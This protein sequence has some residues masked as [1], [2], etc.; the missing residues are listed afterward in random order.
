MATD[1]FHWLYEEGPCFAVAK[2]GGLL[3]QAPPHIDSLE[4]RLRRF[5]QQRDGRPG[6]VYL[7]VPHR[8]D[9]PVSGVLVFA[10]HV[11][12]AR[13]ISRQFEQRTV[14]KKYWALLEGCLSEEEGEWVDYL[15]KVPDQPRGE[16]VDTRR[17]DAR[18]AVLR[19]RRL[20]QADDCA[21]VEI[22]LQTGR[23]HQIRVQAAS[24]GHPVVGDVEY[25]STRPFGPEVLDHRQRW[26]ALHA[27]SLRFD[28]PMHHESRMITAPIPP[29]WP[30]FVLELV[31]D[32]H[33]TVS[34]SVERA[35]SG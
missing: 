2:P 17:S 20:C 22:T 28:H 33:Q 13:R 32:A 5:L 16:I 23:Y 34:E 3:T 26:I 18:V 29:C 24:R 8:L 30:P 12:A 7:G 14:D 19:Y 25:G 6:R 27:R 35:P 21:L 15:R 1:G 10:R 9:R 4:A 31:P 11:R